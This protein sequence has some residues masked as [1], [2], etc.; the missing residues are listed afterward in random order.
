MNT[1]K[2]LLSGDLN[3]S[4][5]L[6]TKEDN[7]LLALEKINK[8][9][10]GALFVLDSGCIIGLFNEHDYYRNVVHKGTLS[11]VVSVEEIMNQKF[12]FVTTNCSI[13][14][15]LK[16]MKEKGIQFMPIFEAEK[17]IGIISKEK[18]IEYIMEKKE[19]M[20]NQ[21]TNYITGSSMT[22]S[23]TIENKNNFETVGEINLYQLSQIT[24]ISNSA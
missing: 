14:D 22:T 3:L 10:V 17:A 20:I 8:N 4:D 16:T 9:R 13:E 1:I 2:D 5:Y 6:I 19:F 24:V 12:P 18:V 21:L 15:C 7:A 23:E 11:L